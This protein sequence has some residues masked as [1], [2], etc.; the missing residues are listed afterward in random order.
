[1]LLL[2]NFIRKSTKYIDKLKNDKGISRSIDITRDVVVR[3]KNTE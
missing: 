1:M 2:T 3:D